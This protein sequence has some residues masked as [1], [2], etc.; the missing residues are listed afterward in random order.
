MGEKVELFS[1]SSMLGFDRKHWEGKLFKKY[2][3]DFSIG[4]KKNLGP[5]ITTNHNKNGKSLSFIVKNKVSQFQLNSLIGFIEGKCP[6]FHYLTI[7][8]KGTVFEEVYNIMGLFD[9]SSY[10]KNELISVPSIHIKI[11]W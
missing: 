7:F 2:P 3:L 6:P 1:D 5:W 8:R 10:M 4:F 9:F 11:T